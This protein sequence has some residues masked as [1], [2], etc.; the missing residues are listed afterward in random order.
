MQ[1]QPLRPSNEPVKSK[2]VKLTKTNRSSIDEAHGATNKVNRAKRAART[3]IKSKGKNDHGTYPKYNHKRK[4]GP[5]ATRRK[6][7]RNGQWEREP[8]AV[9]VAPE[10]GPVAALLASLP[11]P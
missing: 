5:S 6:A 4:N 11:V 2:K 7:R 8:K 1:K 10:A 3:A 9:A